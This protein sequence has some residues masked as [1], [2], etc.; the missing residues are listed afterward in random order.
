[1]RVVSWNLSQKGSA[2]WEFLFRRLEPDV[3]LVQEAIL[4]LD[5]PS[6]Y[7]SL[8]IPG[9]ADGRWG[10]A[11]LS[12]VG[13]LEL[14]WQD[15][16]RGAV[17]LARSVLPG[18][19]AVSIAN[20]HARVIDGRVIPALRETF[21][22]L[23]GRLGDRFIVGG[24]LNTARQAALAWPRNGHREFWEE[25]DA[26]E[27]KEALPLGGVERQSY[28]REW[29]QNKEPTLGNSLQD[30]HLFF[31]ETTRAAVT[32]CLVWDTFETRALSD[33]GPLVVEL[34]VS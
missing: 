12:R 28:W 32:R 17:I 5:L 2:V 4:P 3:A 6:E 29:Q 21:D 33:H 15:S 22:E 7:A 19:G 9:W 34:S 14:V 1:M 25:L 18:I 23:R 13:E 10:S 8:S 16:S 26:S 30:D 20:V 27:L 11:V 24:D 31:D